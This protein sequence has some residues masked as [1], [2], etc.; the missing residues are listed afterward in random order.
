MPFHELSSTQRSTL[1]GF[2]TNAPTAVI[3]TNLSI[4]KQGKATAM[5]LLGNRFWSL[6]RTGA[7]VPA[8]AHP[9]WYSPTLAVFKGG[10]RG[11]HSHP[12]LIPAAPKA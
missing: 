8:C 3:G 12:T 4:E 5:L 2:S 11:M 9:P 7:A 10:P 6:P 1:L